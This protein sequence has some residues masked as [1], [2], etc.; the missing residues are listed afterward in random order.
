MDVL[1]FRLLMTESSSPIEF[2]GE[3]KT[4]HLPPKIR[5]IETVLPERTVA[6][7]KAEPKAFGSEGHERCPL[8]FRCSAI[9][10]G[11]TVFGDVVD[12]P[13]L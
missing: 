4:L 10:T 11:D 13:N 7:S 2:T 1:E 12:L 3:P 6:L 5:Q 9:D 8:Q